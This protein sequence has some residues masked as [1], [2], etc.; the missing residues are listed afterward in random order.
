MIDIRAVT[1]SLSRRYGQF[2]DSGIELAGT[3]RAA[4]KPLAIV[5]GNCQAEPIR[6]L[7]RPAIGDSYALIRTPAVHLATAASSERLK[8]VLPRVSLLIT[9][10]IRDGYHGLDIGTAHI[11]GYLPE[12]CRTITV[13]SIYFRGYHPYLV[14]VSASGASRH[15]T[16]I[17]EYHDLRT[18]EAAR[19]G[20]TGT[21]GLRWITSLPE[22][23]R[24]RG[25]VW[26][27]S[28]TEIIRREND[29]DVRISHRI[30]DPNSP[31]WTLNHP[32]ASLLV[33]VCQQIANHVGGDAASVSA[34]RNEPLGDLRIP[35]D[36]FGDSI[37]APRAEPVGRRT[38][39]VYGKPVLESD[40]IMSNLAHYASRPDIVAAATDQH[41]QLLVDL[42]ASV[43]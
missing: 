25:S 17:G 37:G 33:E 9:Q 4:R 24:Y 8:K 16:T 27:D 7:L 10:Q 40:V 23:P 39:L 34:R 42:F 20:L 31:M 38:W 32:P 2:R 28:L 15:R 29:L 26:A 22:Q 18:V 43:E 14:Y 3:T 6:R 19:R 5:H 35:P 12:H 13:P 21:P 1:A 41:R 11:R 36:H 30:T